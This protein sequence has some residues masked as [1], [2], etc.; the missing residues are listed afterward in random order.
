ML[1]NKGDLVLKELSNR[2]IKG[3]KFKVQLAKK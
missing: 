2:T 3:K 1:A